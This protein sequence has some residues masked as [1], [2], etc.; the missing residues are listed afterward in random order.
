M[1]KLEKRVSAVLVAAGSST[2]MGFDARRPISII[3]QRSYPRK[4]PWVGFLCIRH[5]EAE[6][7]EKNNKK[8]KASDFINLEEQASNS[9][10]AVVQ[11]N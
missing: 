9:R 2:R 8:G 7:V 3:K 10:A 11:P 1:K 6:V 5:G 4:I